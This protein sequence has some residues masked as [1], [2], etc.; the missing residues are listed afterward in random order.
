MKTFPSLSLCLLLPALVFSGCSG[1]TDAPKSTKGKLVIKGSNTIGERLAPRLIAEYKKTQPDVEIELESKGTATGFAG[2]LSDGCDIA[3]ASRVVSLAELQQA[4]SNHLEFNVHTIGHYS[5]AVVVNSKNPVSNL[6]RDQVRDI[7]TGAVQNWKDVGGLDAPINLLIRDPVSGTYLGFREL[8]MED[9]PYASATKTFTNYAGIAKAV[10]ADAT[11]IGYV[12][13]DLLTTP[14]LKAP[15]IRGIIP[16]AL[17][18]NESQYPYSRVLRLYTNKDK[19]S[20]IAL[21]FIQF[22][23]SSQGQEILAQMGFVPRM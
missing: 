7:F 9:K 14:G 4:Q 5:V 18:V 22:V 17:S 1:G 21:D 23:Q 19:E 15:S 20:P 12:S 16:S 13:F 6:S 10:A 11:G 2:L 8:A 3:A